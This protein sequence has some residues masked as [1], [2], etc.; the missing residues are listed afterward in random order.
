MTRISPVI[1]E[2]GN[3]ITFE[4]MGYYYP[5][6]SDAEKMRRFRWE[7]GLDK[8]CYYPIKLVIYPIGLP[9]FVDVDTSIETG[10]LTYYPSSLVFR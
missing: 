9:D 4:Y 3:L 6:L 8:D 10:K 5:F 1:D 2:C 7:H